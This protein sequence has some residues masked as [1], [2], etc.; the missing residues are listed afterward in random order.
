MTVIQV[1]V[2]IEDI[3]AE[4]KHRERTQTAEVSV[5]PVEANEHIANQRYTVF[6]RAASLASVTPLEFSAMAAKD[7]IPYLCTAANASP[8][9]MDVTLTAQR[10]IEFG[11]AYKRRNGG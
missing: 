2:L 8:E 7:V 4:R 6:M 10:L 5:S 1:Q 9:T 3:V 11:E